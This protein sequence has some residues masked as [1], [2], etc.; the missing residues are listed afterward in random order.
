MDRVMMANTVLQCK[1]WTTVSKSSPDVTPAQAKVTP[2]RRNYARS[3]L[4]KHHYSIA[5]RNILMMTSQPKNTFTVFNKVHHE[6]IFLR[7][8]EK[9]TWKKKTL[10]KKSAS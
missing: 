3:A 4:M 8:D 1:R 6:L 2:Q 10:E 9:K 7:E 5:Y